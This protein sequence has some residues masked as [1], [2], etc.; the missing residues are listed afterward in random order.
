MSGNVRLDTIIRS[1]ALLLGG[2]MAFG[3]GNSSSA[4]DGGP[5]VATAEAVCNL[6]LSESGN[7]GEA[8]DECQDGQS[9]ESPYSFGCDF[10]AGAYSNGL[11][12]GGESVHKVACA[13]YDQA[14]AGACPGSFDED[15][16]DAVDCQDGVTLAFEICSGEDVT[17]C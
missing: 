16:A 1:A 8:R 15:E 6:E 11:L 3:C 12:S 17:D 7:V 4:G 9:G 2:T 10:F 5:G 13:A 14:F